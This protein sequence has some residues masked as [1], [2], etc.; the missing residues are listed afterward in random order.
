MALHIKADG[1]KETIVGTG[2]NGTI[3]WAQIKAAIGGGYVE[4]V[5]CDPDKT[6]GYSHI[7]LDENGKFG[8]AKPNRE[9]TKMSTHT[10]HGDV[11]VGDVLFCTEEENGD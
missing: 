11:I 4:H 10:A 5:T 7:Y 1:T 6:G 3:E 2:E 8:D 9:A